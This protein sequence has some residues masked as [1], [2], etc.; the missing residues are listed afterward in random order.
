MEFNSFYNETR[1][2][3]T[4]TLMP[5]DGV[6]EYSLIFLHG[7][8][9]SANNISNIFLYNDILPSTFKVVMPTAPIESVTINMGFPAT[10]WFDILSSDISPESISFDDIKRNAEIIRELIKKEAELYNGQ[11]DKV[12]VGGFSQGCAMSLHI[13]LEHENKL[14]GVL[15][16]SGFLPFQTKANHDALDMLLLHGEEDPMINHKVAELSYK[17]ITGLNSVSFNLI[18]NLGHSIDTEAIKLA[19]AFI[20]KLT[21]K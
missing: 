20:K 1:E 7:L 18:K 8:G 6:P 4:V 21:M 13:A 9:D 17:R 19:K 11:F 10:S 5:K 3:G 15:G 16:F 2:G 12:F 14:G